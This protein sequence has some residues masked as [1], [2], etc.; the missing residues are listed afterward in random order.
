[1]IVALEQ[2]LSDVENNNI[3]LEKFENAL[4]AR[5]AA[6]ALAKS[7]LEGQKKTTH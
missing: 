4:V 3:E 2:D 6:D 5:L 1:M 7:K